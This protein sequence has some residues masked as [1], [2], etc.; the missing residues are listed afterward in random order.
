M[1]SITIYHNPAGG[2]SRNVLGLTRNSGEKPTIFQSFNKEDGEP[3]IDEEGN[4][5]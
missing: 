3:V 5:V 4:R 2:T 1:S